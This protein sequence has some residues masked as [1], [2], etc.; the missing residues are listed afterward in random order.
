MTVREAERIP[1]RRLALAG[2][3]DVLAV[4]LPLATMTLGVA[5]LFVTGSHLGLYPEHDTAPDD[6]SEHLHH[7][8]AVVGMTLAMMSPFALPLG[9]A[10]SRATVW[11]EAPRAVAV[12]VLV[13]VGVWCVA[14]A[15]LHVVGELLSVALTPVGALAV[16]SV[17][18]A[19]GQIGRRRT[20]LLDGCQ[21]T[22]PVLP[23]TPERGA[24]SWGLLAVGR[25]VRVCAVPMT[26]MAL[27]PGLVSLVGVTALLWT[28]RFGPRP[29]RAGLLAAGY[30]LLAA[31]LVWTER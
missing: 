14:A 29:R 27:A 3:G 12:A 19:L 13:F 26:V 30:L 24:A 17:L 25:C 21:L 18:C 16:L 7:V 8:S 2:A 1:S 11:W 28:E 15:G 10:V 22:Q 5:I 23:G 20:A 9:R 31:V 6:V 4:A